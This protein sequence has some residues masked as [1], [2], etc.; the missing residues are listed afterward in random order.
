MI[1]LLQLQSKQRKI[2]LQGKK[3]IN[4]SR[5]RTLFLSEELQHLMPDT[6]SHCR[7]GNSKRSRPYSHEQEPSA[8]V[9][10]FLITLQAKEDNQWEQDPIPLCRNLQ[11]LLPNIIHSCIQYM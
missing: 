8:L 3:S 11:H 9:L 1:S 2:N 10:L 4:H 5:N 6:K 7:K